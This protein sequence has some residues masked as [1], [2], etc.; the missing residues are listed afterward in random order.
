[1]N[2]CTKLRELL[3]WENPLIMPDAYD[4]ISAKMIEKWV[5]MLFNVLVIVLL[6]L[7]RL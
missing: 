6:W 2:K 4:P 5:L 1:M 7:I 3:A